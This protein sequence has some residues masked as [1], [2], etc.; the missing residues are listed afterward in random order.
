[1]RRP[2]LAILP[3]LLTLAA[4]APGSPASAPVQVFAA[5]S[6]GAVGDELIAAYRQEN[7]QADI[8]ATYEGS[9]QLVIQM[10][11]GATPDLLI[12]ADSSTMAQAIG[13]VKELAGATPETIATNALVLATA[14]GNPAAIDSVDDLAASGV[15]TA[16]CAQEVPCGRLGHQELTRQGITPAASTEEASVS[17]VVTKMATGQADAGFIYST[18][19]TAL[20]AAEDITVIDL[21]DLERNAYALALTSTGQAKASAQD[22]ANWLATSEKAAQI[23]TAYGF[24][25]A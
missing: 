18:D 21:P 24:Q 8:T 11:E 19:A 20:S 1:M 23:L 25:P 4:C 17:A 9:S 2:I 7:P 6:L 13:T 12:T 22:F 5:A 10:T 16:I 14:P 15:M 3:L